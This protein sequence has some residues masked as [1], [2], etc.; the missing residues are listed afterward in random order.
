M[1]Q[2]LS[3]R[4]LYKHRTQHN[5]VGCK[6]EHGKQSPTAPSSCSL[7]LERSLPLRGSGGVRTC[8]GTSPPLQAMRCSHPPLSQWVLGSLDGHTKWDSTF[9]G[10]TQV[11]Q[12]HSMEFAYTWRP[13]SYSHPTC[14]T[15]LRRKLSYIRTSSTQS[16]WPTEDPKCNP[17]ALYTGLRSCS[18]GSTS[19]LA[20][21]PHHLLVANG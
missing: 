16:A 3:A 8:S 11:W 4:I 10:T 6:L 13:R 7:G 17:L 14:P 5:E 15:A 9:L 12:L 19:P 21:T 20:R 1:E 18:E 2:H